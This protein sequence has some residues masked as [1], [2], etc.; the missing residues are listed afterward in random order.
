MYTILLIEDDTIVLDVVAHLLGGAGYRVL[1]A[2]DSLS[3]LSLAVSEQPDLVLADIRMPGL[4]GFGLLAAVRANR[5]T[6]STPFLFLTALDDRDSIQHAIR[7][8]ADGYL[9]KPLQPQTLLE[10]IASRLTLAQ[11]RK[12]ALAAD[13]RLA[14]PAAAGGD[15]LATVHEPVAATLKERRFATILYSDIR[16]FSTLAEMLPVDAV[17]DIL[18]DYY[19]RACDVILRQQGVVVKIIGDALL[20]MF[21]S[22]SNASEDHA[23]RALRAA[24][25]LS[26]A[27]EAFGNELAS[28]VKVQGWPGFA[29]GVGVHTGEVMVCSMGPDHNAEVT[30]IGDTVNIAARLESKT[31]E[32]RCAVVASAASA[33]AAGDRFSYAR[34]DTVS[35][36]GRQTPVPIVEVTGF[37]PRAGAVA[38]SELR[39]RF[40]LP[41]LGTG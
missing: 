20:A 26:Q 3:G 29:I 13:S 6:S 27:A 23:A 32:L 8:G 12:R 21:E 15:P 33:R 7:L 14:I 37:A 19:G 4:D 2:A 10:T 38:G 16:K 39:V 31:K 30:V 11:A 1:K 18:N 41:L 36:R 35:V 40:G 22:Q 28:R 25:L 34:R 17:A 5:R 9:I 24:L